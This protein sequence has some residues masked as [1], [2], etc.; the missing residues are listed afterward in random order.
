MM[1]KKN[2]IK[3]NEMNEISVD[4]KAEYMKA[5]RMAS[6]QSLY[7]IFHYLFMFT[8]YQEIMFSDGL[9]SLPAEID[10]IKRRNWY[11][12][13]T[14]GIDD[15]KEE[16]VAYFGRNAANKMLSISHYCLHKS[17]LR[18]RAENLSNKV[19]GILHR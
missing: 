3:L 19:L 12:S 13:E 10:K 5:A 17:W 1:S 8:Q 7:P 9:K 18:F 2:Q 16:L 4:F 11:E 15:C 14:K 6:M